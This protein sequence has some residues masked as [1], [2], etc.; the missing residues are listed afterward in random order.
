MCDRLTVHTD[1]VTVWVGHTATGFSGMGSLTVNRMGMGIRIKLGW[2][3]KSIIYQTLYLDNINME[4][5]MKSYEAI[6]TKT[7]KIRPYH[8]SSQRISYPSFGL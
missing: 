8:E 5:A 4:N 7:Y 2:E 6:Y 3:T 1:T